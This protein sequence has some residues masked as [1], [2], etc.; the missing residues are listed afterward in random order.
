[1]KKEDFVKPEMQSIGFMLILLLGFSCEQGLQPSIPADPESLPFVSTGFW[2]V[3][4]DPGGYTG[5]SYGISLSETVPL[6]VD[7]QHFQDPELADSLFFSRFWRVGGGLNLVFS[8]AV[9]ESN[10]PSIESRISGIL[11]DASVVPPEGLRR[12]YLSDRNFQEIESERDSRSV[13]PPPEVNHRLL[14]TFDPTDPDTCLIVQ[15]SVTVDF[16]V[17]SADSMV[18]YL[19]TGSGESEFVLHPDSNGV[20]RREF[21]SILA[22]NRLYT[23]LEGEALGHARL[24]SAYLTG[25]GFYPLSA[26]TQNYTVEFIL[27]DS[28]SAWTPISKISDDIWQSAPGGLTGGLPVALGNYLTTEDRHGYTL[29]LLSGGSPDSIDE[30]VVNSLSDVLH[31][32]LSFPS[33]DFAFTEVKN[34]D[35]RMVLPVFGG[36]FFARGSLEPLLDVSGWDEMIA[37]GELPEGFGILTDAA[38]GILLQSLWLDPVLEDMLVSWLPLRYYSAMVDDPEGIATLREGYMKYYLYNTERAALS[39]SP[40][41][42]VEYSIADPLLA[43]SP[44]RYFISRGKGVILLE[45]MYSRG[46]LTNLPALLQRFTHSWSSNYWPSIYSTLLYSEKLRGEYQELL[47][48]LFYLPGVPQIKVSWIEDDGI[49]YMNPMEI[50]PGI[51]F[52]LPLDSIQCMVYMPDTSFTRT[53]FIDSGMLQL[54][55]DPPSGITG[56]V[57]AIDLNHQWTIPADFMY[58]RETN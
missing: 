19:D 25:A 58:R 32:S 13:E 15:D 35:G 6:P 16:T 33:A 23:S 46:I 21:T 27:P 52:S 30:L 37:R 54:V 24:T 42:T 44:Q 4:Y 47:R 3:R 29:S 53:T 26:T 1:M 17:S 10:D 22:I 55:I 45:Y 12:I 14:I 48:R 28:I 50:Q 40:S 11:Q 9:P 49:V 51:P 7:S 43:L 34:P 36:V 5:G 41:L 20:C 38:R 57:R 56:N 18:F 31:S 39:G 8:I 2:S